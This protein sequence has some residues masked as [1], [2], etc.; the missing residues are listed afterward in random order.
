MILCEMQAEL[1]GNAMLAVSTIACKAG[2]S[3]KELLLF[4]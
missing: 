2:A 3:K 4:F 1:G